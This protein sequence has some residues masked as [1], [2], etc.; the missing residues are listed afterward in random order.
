MGIRNAASIVA[1]ILATALGLA[2]WFAA[3]VGALIAGWERI[4]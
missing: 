3:G 4:R 2:L 1:I